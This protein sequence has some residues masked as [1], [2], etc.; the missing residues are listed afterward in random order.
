[1][2]SFSHL[3]SLCSGLRYVAINDRDASNYYNRNLAGKTESLT[4]LLISEEIFFLT[5]YKKLTVNRIGIPG[6]K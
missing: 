2:A 4:F 6:E 3:K 5:P 1:M